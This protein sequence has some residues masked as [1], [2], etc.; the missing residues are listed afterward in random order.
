MGGDDKRVRVFDKNGL[1]SA[2][3]D[4]EEGAD[5][6]AV[7][8]SDDTLAVSTGGPTVIIIKRK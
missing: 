1:E 2:H 4:I 3:L 7:S 8:P 6:A 5:L